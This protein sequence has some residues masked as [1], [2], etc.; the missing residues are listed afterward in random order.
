LERFLLRGVTGK[1]LERAAHPKYLLGRMVRGFPDFCYVIGCG[2]GNVPSVPEFSPDSRS[3]LPCVLL[4]CGIA[5]RTRGRSLDH[6]K[7]SKQ[8]ESREEGATNNRR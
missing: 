3:T 8:R 7:E 4:D 2:I 5:S 6:E 1:V